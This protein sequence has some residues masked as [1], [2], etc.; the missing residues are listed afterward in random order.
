LLDRIKW[1]YGFLPA[2]GNLERKLY[3]YKTCGYRE[4]QPAV[5]ENA[6][7]GACISPKVKQNS[8]R[9]CGTVVV[10]TDGPVAKR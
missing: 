5:A 9:T 4:L 7:I 8:N 6:T 3:R 2:D 10:T 1:V